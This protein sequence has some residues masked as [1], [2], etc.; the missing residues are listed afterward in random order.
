MSGRSSAA[1]ESITRGSSTFSIGGI[2]GGEPVARIACSNCTV[3]VA[4]GGQLH[5]QVC[6]RRRSRPSPCRYCTLRC[7]TS[8]PVP[9]G[10]PL[11]DV[12]LERAQL[13]EIDLRLAELDAPRL[14]V[15]R[16]VEQLGDV[17]QRL[18]R[19]AA[20]IDADAA[21]IRFG[22]DERDAEAEIGGEKRRGV[23]A[24][25][26]RRRRRVEWMSY[27]VSAATKARRH[28]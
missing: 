15:A 22:I 12:V 6:A 4:A 10:Q 26:R 28:E 24:R 5:R 13:G 1:V 16:L 14:R 18:R 27:E 9:L 20:A 25:A 3:L 23:S 7:F 21:G 8:C 17:Q 19:N 2:A 11:D